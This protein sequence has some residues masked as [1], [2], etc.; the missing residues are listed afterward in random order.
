M[1]FQPDYDFILEEDIIVP[2]R[3]GVDL[4]TD[5]Y[6][7]KAKSSDSPL[8]SKYPTLLHRTPY[9]KTEV[10]KLTNF[11]RWF[12]CRGYIAVIQD[13]RGCFGSGGDVNFLVPEAE[14]GFDTMQWIKEQEW[15]NGKVGTWG[16]SWAG[17]T[18][19][20]L[21]GLGPDNLTTMI[22]NQSGSNGYS[23]SVRQGGA[24][25]LRFLA[26][27]FWHS[28]SNTQSKLKSDL[29]IDPALN[30][31]AIPFGEWLTRMPIRKGQTQ[32]KLVPQ[33]EKWA[34]ELLT[35][36]DYGEY[37]KHPSLAP[38]EHWDSFPDIP[39]L[40]CGGWYDSY[41]R[42]TFENYCGLSESK[43]GPVK[44][45][46]GP[47]THGSSTQELTYAGN[48][49]FGEEASIG[50]FRNL[51]LQW[52]DYW[53]RNMDNEVSRLPPVRIFVMGGGGGYRTSSDRLFHGGSWRDENEWPLSRTKFTKFYLHEGGSLSSDHPSATIPSTSYSFDPS[54]PVPS[55]GGNVSSLREVGDFPSG[56]AN[57]ALA[58]I[59]TRVHEVM[60]PGGYDQVEGATFYGCS[61]PFLPI[62]SRP[63]VLVFQT[64]PLDRDIEVTGPIEVVLWVT[65]SA[66]DTDFTAK[67]IDV[68]PS[69]EWYPLGYSLNLTDS[70]IRIRYRNGFDQEELL[71]PG[72]IVKVG[73][74][75]YPTSNFFVAGHRI[76]LDI[77]SSNFPRFDVN[78][79]SG[80]P[81]GRNR[82][83]VIAD[84]TIFH[85]AEQPSHVI[86]PII[87]I[88]C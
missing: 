63:D 17:W 74:T 29:S 10:E 40:L 20:A 9:N 8:P 64:E 48:V 37:W 80:E 7:P 65:S 30:L 66:V 85:C 88:Q 83:T 79:N 70:I 87:P 61:P 18:Q 50:N 27:A 45:I 78:P 76:R 22:P 60:L 33:Y 82:R 53:M 1:E 69:N 21:A 3:D 43:K 52:Y 72:E 16:T 34:F 28:A 49:E 86:L 38:S 71:T 46:V 81:L 36:S 23:S 84:N 32:L 58:P 44:V 42:A 12:A 25:E 6:Y 77:S 68:Y 41:T 55:V 15:S 14:D 51:H 57:P 13:C 73:I 4:A 54:F 2:A 47:W 35:N 5:V 39:I 31:G 24:L 75:L 19:T 26:W 67:L 11:C 56:L 59:S 62:G